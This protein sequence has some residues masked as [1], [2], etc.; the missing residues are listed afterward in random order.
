METHKILQIVGSAMFGLGAILL[1]V[2]TTSM[3]LFVGYAVLTLV[4]I[5]VV[6]MSR[7]LRDNR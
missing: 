6:G 3:G 1:A 7:R 4:G 5:G 2:G